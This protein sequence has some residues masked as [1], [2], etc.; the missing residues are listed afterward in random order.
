VNIEVGIDSVTAGTVTRVS[1]NVNRKDMCIH[2]GF[3]DAY[4]VFCERSSY[5]FGEM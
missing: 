3:G 1:R 2:N 5:V 4:T